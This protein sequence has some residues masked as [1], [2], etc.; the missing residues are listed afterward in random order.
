MTPS[1]RL[2]TAAEDR[3]DGDEA[4]RSLI[5]RLRDE[6]ADQEAVD[7]FSEARLLRASADEIERLNALVS[8]LESRDPK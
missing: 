6:A 8:R 5:E 4:Q 2:V 3:G 1:N 7:M